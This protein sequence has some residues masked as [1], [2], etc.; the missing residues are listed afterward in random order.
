MIL[1]LV[2]TYEDFFNYRA[3]KM[4]KLSFLQKCIK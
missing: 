3:C 1:H 2:Q 4:K